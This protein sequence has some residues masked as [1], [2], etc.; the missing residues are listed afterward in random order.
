MLTTQAIQLH[1]MQIKLQRLA[2]TT[3]QAEERAKVAEDTA[4]AAVTAI[5]IIKPPEQ[6]KIKLSNRDAKNFWPETHTRDHVDQR[7]SFLEL[8]GRGRDIPQCLGSGSLGETTAG[9]GCRFP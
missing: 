2:L 1:E 7:T 6:K 3:S 9:V 8:V 4:S 5:G